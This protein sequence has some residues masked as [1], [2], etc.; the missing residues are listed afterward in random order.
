MANIYYI[1]PSGLLPGSYPTLTALFAAHAQTNGDTIK[2]LNTGTVTEDSDLY[3]TVPNV[4]IE[5][6]DHADKPTIHFASTHF[7]SFSAFATNGI[8]QDVKITNTTITPLFLYGQGCICQRCWFTCVAATGYSIQVG[9]TSVGITIQ[10]NVFIGCG[11]GIY[12]V[13]AINTKVYNNT[14]Y[15]YTSIGIEASYSVSS[16]IKNNIINGASGA[17]VDVGQTSA[18]GLVENYNLSYNTTTTLTGTNDTSTISPGLISPPTNCTPAAGS[19]LIGLVGEDGVVTDDYYGQA[20]TSL[21][22]GLTRGAI[23]CNY[24]APSNLT[25]HTGDS[26]T[27]VAISFTEVVGPP[28]QYILY[29]NEGATLDTTTATQVPAITAS[30]CEEAISLFTLGAEYTFAIRSDYGGG[31]SGIRISAGVTITMPEKPGRDPEIMMQMSN[32]GGFTYGNE[33]RESLGK[34]GEYKKRVHFHSLGQSRDK[35]FRFTMT[36]PIPFTMIQ[37]YIDVDGEDEEG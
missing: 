33:H 22:Y 14:I 7:L 1:D 21:A 3:I 27:P 11:T 25:V 31:E 10:N 18:T 8:I 19:V 28:L 29:Y 37:C 26:E 17:T 9:L 30:P 36:D 24:A 12:L 5:A 23:E 20:R 13:G 34:I 16:T 6:Y 32:D 4:T 35:I 15:N 2:I